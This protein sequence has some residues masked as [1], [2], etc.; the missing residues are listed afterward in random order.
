M[1]MKEIVKLFSERGILVDPEALD[2]ISSKDDPLSFAQDV[3]SKLSESSLVLTLEEI[4]KM[5]SP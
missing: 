4:K 1:G 3:I 2:Y 5:E